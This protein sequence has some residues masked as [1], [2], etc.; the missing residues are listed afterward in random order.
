VT[1]HESLGYFSERYGFTVIGGILQSV[2]SVA[3]ASAQ[4]LAALVDQIKA[5]GA[6]AIFLDAA[7]NP[8]LA[9]QIASETGV[10]V[11]TDLHLE[12]LTD[13]P[14]APTYAVAVSPDRQT[15]ILSYSPPMEA[16]YGGQTSLYQMPLD[17][18]KPPQLLI[19]P[20]IDQDQYFQPTWSPDGNQIYLTYINYATIQS[21][22]IMRMAYPDGKPE[23]LIDHAQWPRVLTTI[24]SL[25]TWHSIRK[26]ERINLPLPTPMGQIRIRSL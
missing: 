19:T 7:D 8:T 18:S 3:S 13:G 11:V 22:E 9:Q 1:N 16:P 17:G 21:Y 20:L 2:S 25:F 24:L 26:M 23:T 15:L 14:P 4:Q 12:S 10:K 5:S 6:P